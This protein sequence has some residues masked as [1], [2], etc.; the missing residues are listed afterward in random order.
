[1]ST[2]IPFIQEVV[3]P[4]R[5]RGL[6]CNNRGRE[7][8]LTQSRSRK[9]AWIEMQAVKSNSSPTIGRSRK[10]AWIEI[11]LESRALIA[12]PVAPVRERG[13]KYIL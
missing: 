1:M 11:V 13:L 2:V 5:E 7:L 12:D 10:G 8:S 9:G 6:K 3:A 4:V